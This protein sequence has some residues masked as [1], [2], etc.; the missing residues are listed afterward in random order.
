M[1]KITVFSSIIWFW[2][3]L[4]YGAPVNFAVINHALVVDKLMPV[5]T[6]VKVRVQQIADQFNAGLSLDC[7][8]ESAF[9]RGRPSNQGF[10]LKLWPAIDLMVGDVLTY[11]STKRC[12]LGFSGGTGYRNLGVE[13]GGEGY[14]RLTIGQ[15]R[16]RRWVVEV[17]FPDYGFSDD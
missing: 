9:D 12:F 4:A 11:T 16:G 1:K 10:S 2:A 5:G 3:G 6:E 15:D 7:Y 17:K 13:P 14:R 8:P